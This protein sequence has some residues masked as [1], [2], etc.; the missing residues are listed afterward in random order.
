[1]APRL[2]AEIVRSAGGPTWN[3]GRPLFGRH[4]LRPIPHWKG[5]GPHERTWKPAEN[6]KNAQEAVKDSHAKFTMKP[7]PT[8][9]QLAKLEI[10]ISKLPK[11]FFQPS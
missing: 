3:S 8:Q 6:L 9:T 2:P 7:K 11:G 4:G 5:Y 10:P 1:M